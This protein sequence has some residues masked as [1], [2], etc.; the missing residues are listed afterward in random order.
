M[1]SALRQR[2][3]LRVR[4]REIRLSKFVRKTTY[5]VQTTLFFIIASANTIVHILQK[6]SN[7]CN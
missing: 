2:N 4:V 3:M 7:F 6:V 5:Q 1:A